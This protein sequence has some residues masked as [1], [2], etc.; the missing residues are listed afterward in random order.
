MQSGLDEQIGLKHPAGP[1]GLQHTILKQIYCF[2]KKKKI[3]EAK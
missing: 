3:E 2:L 1:Y